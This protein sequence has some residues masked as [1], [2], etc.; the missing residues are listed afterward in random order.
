MRQLTIVNQTSEIIVWDSENKGRS[1]SKILLPS[2]ST[3]TTISASCSDITLSS[4]SNRGEAKQ[5]WTASP[6]A[7]TIQLPMSLGAMWKVVKVPEECPWRVYRCKVCGIMIVYRY[8][9]SC[10]E[11]FSET[12]FTTHPAPSRFGLFPV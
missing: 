4:I 2:L 9:I 3:S 8:P 11:G 6:N 7:Y 10:V 1:E 5:D 12:S